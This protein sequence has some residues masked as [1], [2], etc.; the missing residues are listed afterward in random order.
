MIFRSHH[1]PAARIWLVGRSSEF[2]HECRQDNLSVG[3]LSWQELVA[4]A[5]VI[6]GTFWNEPGIEERIEVLTRVNHGFQL[7]GLPEGSSY[8]S[9]YGSL[10]LL[11]WFLRRWPDGAGSAV[12][13]DLLERM[14][15]SKTEPRFPSSRRSRLE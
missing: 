7:D 14:V 6:I 5:D 13:I 8:D 10:A 11:A 9:R 12:A 1:A 15:E 2:A 3:R 4:L